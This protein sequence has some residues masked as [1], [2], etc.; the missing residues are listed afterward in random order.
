VRRTR[1]QDEGAALTRRRHWIHSGL[2]P[3]LPADAEDERLGAKP[4]PSLE[5]RRAAYGNGAQDYTRDGTTEVGYLFANGVRLAR[6][7]NEP[8]QSGA[9]PDTGGNLRVFFELGDRLGSTSAALDK[10]TGE[11]AERAT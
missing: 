6:L 10:E 4:Y 9:P 2:D 5:L 11:L 3:P 8:N 1:G 7:V